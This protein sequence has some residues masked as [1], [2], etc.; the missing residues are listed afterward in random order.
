[1]LRLA[2]SLVLSMGSTCWQVLLCCEY[3]AR[4][5]WNARLGGNLVFP[6]AGSAPVCGHRVALFVVYL[7]DYGLRSS[8]SLPGRNCTC[9]TVVVT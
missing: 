3:T 2:G 9:L 4:R 5:A 6:G 8:F 1:M 7:R